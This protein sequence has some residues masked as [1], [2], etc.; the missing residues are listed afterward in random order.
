MGIWCS[1][2]QAEAQVVEENRHAWASQKSLAHAQGERAQM[3]RGRG[4]YIG[5]GRGRGKGRESRDDGYRARLYLRGEI[6]FHFNI[7]KNCYS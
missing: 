4:M 2:D 3:G 1:I 7:H 6:I 5:R